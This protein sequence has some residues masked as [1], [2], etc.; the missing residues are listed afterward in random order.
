MQKKRKLR[1]FIRK[2]KKG[3]LG[4]YFM[5]SDCNFVNRFQ[6]LFFS[7]AF[8]EFA[9]AFPFRTLPREDQVNDSMFLI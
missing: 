7:V 4:S 2:F 6:F 5:S 8:L 3:D 9:S 1:E